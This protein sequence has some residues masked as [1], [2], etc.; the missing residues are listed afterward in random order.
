MSRLFLIVVL[1]AALVAAASL[2]ASAFERRPETGTTRRS[3]A[4]Q[5]IS[6][7]LLITVMCGVATGW[8]GAE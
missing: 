1:L 8:L 5:K 3:G 4:I 2:V 7:A 6:Y